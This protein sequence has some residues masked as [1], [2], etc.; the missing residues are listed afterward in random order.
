MLLK[1]VQSM[2][3]KQVDLFSNVGLTAQRVCTAHRHPYHA[4]VPW[5]DRLRMWEPLRTRDMPMSAIIARQSSVNNILG[6]FCIHSDTD[7]FRYTWH[8]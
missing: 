3:H 1:Y 5:L 8:M 7:P 2:P 6:L 4:S